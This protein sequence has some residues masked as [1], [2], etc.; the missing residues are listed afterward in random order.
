MLPKAQAVDELEAVAHAAGRD[1]TLIPLI[2][3]ALGMRNLDAIAGAPYVQ[4]LAFGTIDFRVDLGMQADED[5]DEV[6]LASFRAELALASRFAG[7]QQPID[8]VTVAVDD[9]ER[10][11]A[12]VRRGLRFGFGAKLCIHPKQVAVVHR[13]LAPSEQQLDWARRVLAA[14]A[15]SRG[16]AVQIDGK[17]VDR[18]VILQAEDFVARAERNQ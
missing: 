5:G 10:V 17:M 12:D 8:G 18:P 3:S 14:V 4:R 1:A 16:A 9:A 13:T 6:E 7:L 15:V 11:A 2:E